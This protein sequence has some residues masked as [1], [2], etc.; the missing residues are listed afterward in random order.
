MATQISKGTQQ[1]LSMLGDCGGGNENE[2]IA[3]M[4]IG[5]LMWI[6]GVGLAIVRMSNLLQLFIASNGG[7]LQCIGP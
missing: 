7:S 6:P 3:Y 5:S 4:G 2:D 1:Y